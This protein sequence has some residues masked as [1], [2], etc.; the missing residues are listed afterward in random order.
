[1]DKKKSSIKQ[2][3][4]NYAEDLAHLKGEIDNLEARLRQLR[5]R[6]ASMT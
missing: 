4:Y 2:M 1:M 5:G 6:G 3:P